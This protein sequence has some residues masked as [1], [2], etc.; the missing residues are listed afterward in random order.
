MLYC[1][2]RLSI[3]NVLFKYS[4]YFLFEA[5]KSACW[6]ICTQ[7]ELYLG[8]E[9]LRVSQYTGNSTVEWKLREVRNDS[10]FPAL[11]H[12]ASTDFSIQGQAYLQN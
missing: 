3:P 12:L 6:D 7:G 9:D 11:S 10:I 4:L 8:Q 2:S 5:G 1:V